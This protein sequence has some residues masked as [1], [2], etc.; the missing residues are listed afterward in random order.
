MTP[1]QL[2]RTVGDEELRIAVKECFAWQAT[3]VLVGTAV[4]NI[5]DRLVKET[6]YPEDGALRDTDDLIMRE[7]AQRWITGGV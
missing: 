1:K 4:R 6:G 2:L 7:A 3:G 5:A